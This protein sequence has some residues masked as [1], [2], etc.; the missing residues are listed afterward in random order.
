[1]KRRPKYQTG[2]TKVR[3]LSRRIT[4]KL[5]YSKAMNRN[6]K[7]SYEKAIQQEKME[8]T[9]TKS[10]RQDVAGGQKYPIKITLKEARPE[11]I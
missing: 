2:I 3:K 10:R 6:N 1:M 11:K 8:P 7:R 4:E 5:E 9:R